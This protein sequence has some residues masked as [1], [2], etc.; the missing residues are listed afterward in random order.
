MQQHWPNR[1]LLQHRRWQQQT[2]ASATTAT[3]CLPARSSSTITGQST[4]SHL[5]CHHSRRNGCLSWCVGQSGRNIWRSADLQVQRHLSR[6]LACLT[7]QLVQPTWSITG[8]ADW[9]QRS[10]SRGRRR[11]R[12]HLVLAM[13]AWS[14]RQQRGVHRRRCET[15]SGR[16]P[17]SKE[18][19]HA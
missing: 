7:S 14:P 19:R 1:A 16:R 3:H 2:G 15:E 9:D 4:H 18:T 10:E 6:F 11:H 17:V 12:P 5:R 13:A 8:V